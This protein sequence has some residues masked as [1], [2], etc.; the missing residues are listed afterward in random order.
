MSGFKPE[1]SLNQQ[2]EA[3]AGLN[4]LK[5]ERRRLNKSR[6]VKKYAVRC[7]P[8]APERRQQI[9]ETIKHIDEEVKRLDEA[10]TILEDNI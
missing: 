6:L 1:S 7:T 4:D 3:R 9:R 10:I 8:L 5:R 2:E